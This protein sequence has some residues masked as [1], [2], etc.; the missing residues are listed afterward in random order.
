MNRCSL[1]KNMVDGWVEVI[2]NMC[3]YSRKSRVS[4]SSMDQVLIGR[5]MRCTYV[6][7]IC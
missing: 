2:L 7:I 6:A 5:F 3:E 1:S 4:S